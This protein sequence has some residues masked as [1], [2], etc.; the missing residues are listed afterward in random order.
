MLGAKFD[1]M[2]VAEDEKHPEQLNRALELIL[3]ERMRVGWWKLD[4]VYFDTAGLS[5]VPEGV[6]VRRFLGNNGD[7]LLVVDNW[8]RRT[9]RFR[10]LGVEIDL[11]AEP[12]RVLVNPLEGGR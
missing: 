2:R 3:G 12:I 1:V 9:G 4:P 5:E 11:P 8:H 7:T 6:D 10:F